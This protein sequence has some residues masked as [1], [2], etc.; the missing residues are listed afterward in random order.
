[1]QAGWYVYTYGKVRADYVNI[2]LLKRYRDARLHS[3][4]AIPIHSEVSRLSLDP[5]PSGL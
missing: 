1:M 4:V 5:T 2:V 3:S